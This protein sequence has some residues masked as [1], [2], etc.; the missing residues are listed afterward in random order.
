MAWRYL[1]AAAC[2]PSRQG[3]LH[4]TGDVR[5]GASRPASSAGTVRREHRRKVD[6][7]FEPE[8]RKAGARNRAKMSR[9]DPVAAL[10]PRSGED[11]EGWTT[12]TRRTRSSTARSISG[13]LAPAEFPCPRRGSLS[14]ASPASPSTSRRPA[15]TR[16]SVRRT[17]RACTGSAG[18][19]KLNR[20]KASCHVGL[21]GYGPAARPLAGASEFP[22][23]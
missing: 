14:R 5:A 4:V 15:R 7:E 10:R 18:R 23:R 21:S 17:R 16:L 6:V 1:G 9:Q 8:H 12:S 19:R 2:Q 20:R 13:A 11:D 3:G 22:V